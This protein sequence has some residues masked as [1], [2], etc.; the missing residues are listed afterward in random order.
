MSAEP[1]A[2]RLRYELRGDPRR[3]RI[4]PASTVGRSDGLWRHTCFEAFVRIDDAPWYLELN[5]SPSGQWA[6][7]R[8]EGY[9]DGMGPLELE[10]P[11]RIVV[12]REEPAEPA[13]HRPCLLE[14]DALV[15]LPLLSGSRGRGL[16]LGLCAV[17][18]DDAGG[19]SYWALHHAPGR[20][21]FHHPH[22]FALELPCP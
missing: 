8:L 1:G 21:D 12:S 3:I 18:E 15:R 9:R 7:Y 22:A 14:L 13:G 4:P 10:E 6:A 20:P 11:P 2:L 19:L 16:R 5:F 17:V